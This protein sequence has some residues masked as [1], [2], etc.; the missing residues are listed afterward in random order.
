MSFSPRLHH[1]RCGDIAEYMDLVRGPW[2]LEYQQLSRG[3]LTAENTG[4]STARSVIYTECLNQC[5]SARGA[6]RPGMLVFSLPSPRSRAGRWWGGPCPDDT[7]AFA[8]SSREIDV[9]FP[10]EYRNLLAI[11]PEE[12]F[13]EHFRAATGEEPAFLDGSDPFLRLD[14]AVLAGFERD[15]TRIASGD[16]CLPA[17]FSL[18]R[19]VAE[20][21]GTGGPLRVAESAC[22][23]ARSRGVREAI[24]IWEDAGYELPISE[25]CQRMRISRRTLEHW[26]RHLLGQ[27]P[28]QYLKR[29]R[30]N[31]AHRAL[32]MADP[33]QTS[34][35]RIAMDF[36][37]Y[38]LGRFAV[39]H[40]RHFGEPPSRTLRR[41]P[42]Q[43][44]R[45][46][47]FSSL[48]RPQDEE[49]A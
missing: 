39:E 26:F 25:L 47:V 44:G 41:S 10:D 40:R 21:L 15:W 48:S 4:V 14:P 45:V 46:A 49:Q 5:F 32:R 30:L 34:V 38:E 23:P 43:G 13:R 37:F 11:L 29:H 20:A 3:A 36:G 8:T 22:P 28:Y 16:V 12:G 1:E 6:M 9:S 35:T 19:A 18:C 17:G 2:E 24:G 42:H 31:L 27:S 7:L 33:S